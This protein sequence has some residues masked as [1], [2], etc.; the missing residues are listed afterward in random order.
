MN[1]TE[2]N[3]LVAYFAA[4]FERLAA[5]TKPARGLSAAERIELVDW[6]KLE[7]R[8]LSR[9]NGDKHSCCVRVNPGRRVVRVEP[10]PQPHREHNMDLPACLRNPTTQANLDRFGLP[11]TAWVRLPQN[12]ALL[13]AMGRADH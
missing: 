6:L 1:S 12:P 8:R 11:A 3:E 9:A 4:E 7:F 13:A 5:S 2:R 10:A